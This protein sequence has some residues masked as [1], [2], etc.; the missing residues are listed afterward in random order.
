MAWLDTIR[1]K[2]HSIALLALAALIAA[3]ASAAAQTPF[4]PQLISGPMHRGI[5]RPLAQESWLHRPFSAGWFM[6][7]AQGSPL[8]DDWVG[9]QRGFVGGY[10]FGWDETHF[11]GA[12]MRFSFGSIETLDSQRAIAAQVAADP[13]LTDEFNARR[14]ADYSQ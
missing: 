6:G 13:T 9:L 7:M 5:G 12:E 4:G 3:P 1:G 14:D 8:I 11:W 2:C 10:R